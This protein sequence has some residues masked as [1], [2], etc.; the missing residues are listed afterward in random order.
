MA[1]NLEDLIRGLAA[2]GELSHISLVGPTD[3]KRKK[4][5]AAFAMSSKFGVS[6]AEHEDPVE[7]IRIACTTA[8]MKPQR[9]PSHRET[10]TVEPTAAEVTDVDDLM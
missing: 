5:R 3:V 2:R 4:F 10:I 1:D 6:F 7:A 9:Q 8:K